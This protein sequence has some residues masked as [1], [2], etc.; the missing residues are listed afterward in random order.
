MVFVV[1]FF[2]P[3]STVFPSS[4]F[5]TASAAS[6]P[7][8]LIGN[9]S[10]LINTIS[11]DNG[12]SAQ[13]FVNS[14]GAPFEEMLTGYQLGV[15]SYSDVVNWSN[16]IWN[17]T[18]AK[19]GEENVVAFVFKSFAELQRYGILNQTEIEW[20]LDHYKI[21]PNGL[22][23]TPWDGANDFYLEARY[24]LY[25][26]YWAD[27]YDHNTTAWNVTTAY[28]NFK[29][30][31]GHSA[32][33]ATLYVTSTNGTY[34]YWGAT[35]PRWYDEA[36]QTCDT[37][38]TFYVIG[39]QFGGL[40]TTDALNEAVNTW[41]WYN[42]HGWIQNGVQSHYMYYPGGSRT[43][44]GNSY[45]CESGGFMEL[46]LKLE[47]YYGS[48]LGNV[49]RIFTD[50]Y[51]RYIAEGWK[52]P[53]W[54]TGGGAIVHAASYDGSEAN[55]ETRSS[56][57]LMA[58]S[59]LLGAWSD[60]NSTQQAALSNMLLGNSTTNPAWLLLY[61]NSNLDLYD[62]SLGL[63]KLT[64]DSTSTVADD[65][66]PSCM[67][68]SLIFMEGIVPQTATLAV[69]IQEYFYEDVNALTDAQL[70]NINITARTV[71]FSI[72]K[73]GSVSFIF[74]STVT[75]SFSNVGTYTVT[76]A[77][78]WNSITNT[79]YDGALPT[80][81]IYI[82]IVLQGIVSSSLDSPSNGFSATSHTVTFTY[83]PICVGDT[84]R[85]ASLWTN[86]TGSW[87]ATESNSTVVVNDSS[88]NS[89][90][91]TFTAAGVYVW[92][93]EVFN[94]TSGTFA[95][96]NYTLTITNEPTCY[97]LLTED[98][99]QATYDRGQSVTLWVDVLNQ[100]CPPLSSTLTLTVTG[101]GGYYY[102][103]FQTVNVTADSVWEYSFTW[104]VPAVAG[105]YVVEV[106][107]VPMQLTAYDA[108]WLTVV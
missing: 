47:Y 2:T 76:F 27:L 5:D 24:L 32:A 54:Q 65:I 33:P 52:S 22:P 98:P 1:L 40:N 93:V 12:W 39:S 99:A 55:T 71:T 95:P 59:S 96:S 16:Y 14:S 26:Y 53:Q 92:N 85:N 61:T 100:L 78:D 80:N 57:T 34:C 7:Q 108:V 11:S 107:L 45:E 64:N 70:F 103:D 25:G 30:A 58:L 105:T 6:D 23:E 77:S 97:L 86:A 9:L 21:L 63:F 56:N 31:V 82:G 90:Q 46:A 102:F 87:A 88:Q 38:M 15:Y 4:A 51:D 13:P 44:Y 79:V 49:S 3:L 104:S 18:Y 101:P 91:Y 41:D 19:Y 69:P 75:Q 67:I 72:G 28:A 10:A 29:W 20:G 68:A 74:N 81:R 8:G 62:S 106:S 48:S 50:M 60:L 17:Y 43:S 42:D 36:M 84:I 94:S 89:F 66:Y 83:T 37:F 73:A 35:S